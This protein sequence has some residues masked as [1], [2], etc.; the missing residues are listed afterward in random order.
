MADPGES[1]EEE[2]RSAEE[3][4]LARSA[5]F[6]KELGLTDLVLTQVLFIIGLSWVGVAARLGPA[7]IVFWLLAIVLFYVPTALVVIH[8]NRLM[9][10]EGG[11]YQWA[12]LGFGEFVGFMVAWNLWL[13]VIVLTSE[14]GLIVATNVSYALGPSAA[15]MAG[16]KGVI[17]AATVVVTLALVLVS[18]LGLGVGKWVHNAGGV[19][20]IVIFIALVALPVVNRAQGHLTSYHPFAI[21]MPTL[22][23]FSLN[24][25]GKL[26]SGALGGFEYVA[27]FAGECRNPEKT[28]GRSVIIAAPLIAVMFILGTS[29]VLA[30][31]GPDQV[32]LIGPIP[33]VL[34]LGTRPLRHRL[35]HRPRGDPLDAGATPGPGQRQLHRQHPAA[36]GRG[37]GP[38]PPRLVHAAASE[39]PHPRELDPL[40]GGH[41][42]GAGARG[43]RGRGP[44]G[45]VPAVPDRRGHLLRPHLPGDVRPAHLRLPWR[46]A[47]ALARAPDRLR[48]GLSHDPALRG[49][50]DLS[51]RCRGRPGVVRRQ[52]RGRHPG[53]QPGGRR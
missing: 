36:H 16:S 47:A 23:L 43:R 13:F 25:L 30:F 26:G 32:D 40:R 50:L 5:V 1:P 42:P 21:A 52:D 39:A 49:G 20:L 44:A 51:H 24:I 3:R 2:L 27:I 12:K 22:S 18:M 38:P 17:M 34:S 19:L 8:L 37:L 28:I 6:K 45:G 11:L 35:E 41:H 48:L 46:R 10:L 14:I 29:S 9:P 7:H 53:I 31:L 4:V 15:W 33:Q